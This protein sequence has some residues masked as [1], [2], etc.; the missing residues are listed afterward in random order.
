M[1]FV[2]PRRRLPLATEPSFS[3]PRPP[4]TLPRA[5]PPQNGP[6]P[7]QSAPTHVLPSYGRP[8][9]TFGVRPNGDSLP[10]PTAA[11]AEGP[12]G[13]G[14]PKAEPRLFGPAEPAKACQGQQ[15]PAPL[16]PQHRPTRA[17]LTGTQTS[18][19]VSPRSETPSK[20]ER[21]LTRSQ[22]PRNTA[23]TGRS[24]R[25]LPLPR[26]FQGPPPSST[27]Y[28]PSRSTARASSSSHRPGCPLGSWAAA[29]QATSAEKDLPDVS[30]SIVLRVLPARP[31]R[32]GTG[33]GRRGR[34]A[35]AASRG[36][37]R[38]PRSLLW[39]CLE[40][41]LLPAPAAGLLRTFVALQA[42]TKGKNHQ[43]RPCANCT[44]RGRG[45][46]PPCPQRDTPGQS[47]GSRRR[48]RPRSLPAPPSPPRRQARGRASPPPR[49][50]RAHLRQDRQGHI[51]QLRLVHAVHR[52]PADRTGKTPRANRARSRPPARPS[53]ATWE[54][55]PAAAARP[56]RGG[57]RRDHPLVPRRLHPGR[58]HPP[59]AARRHFPRGAGPRPFGTAPPWSPA[60]WR[61]APSSRPRPPL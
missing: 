38:A 28:P 6:C 3:L 24:G 47:P 61:P 12:Q 46:S 49:G 11:A 43:S 32:V 48:R 41:L 19:F 36:A 37:G 53:G 20:T 10:G 50:A 34:A 39:R 21:N 7:C 59:P 16:E 44:P 15:R 8:G 30:Q 40:L 58:Q 14:S 4:R 29:E 25:P 54:P 31:P 57:A 13:Q 56:C 55:P 42:L 22:I 17:T 52:R 60:P 35:A 33:R 51:H 45:S 2:H 26:G 9:G 27:G 23:R 18:S 5:Q 1:R